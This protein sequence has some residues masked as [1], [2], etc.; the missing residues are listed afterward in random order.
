MTNEAERFI[1]S[2]RAKADESSNRSVSASLS[3]RRAGY[4]LL[5]NVHL[6]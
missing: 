3:S 5:Q 2:L 4:L 6:T 1:E